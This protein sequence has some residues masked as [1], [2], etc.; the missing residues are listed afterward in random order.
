MGWLE[1]YLMEGTPST[2]WSARAVL[3]VVDDEGR[4]EEDGAGGIAQFVRDY[5]AGAAK[6]FGH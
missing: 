5:R 6:Q 4:S 2:G 3:G 1:R